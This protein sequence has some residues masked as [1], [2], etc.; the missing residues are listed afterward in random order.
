MW[1]FL[2]NNVAQRKSA[3]HEEKDATRMGSATGNGVGYR[4]AGVDETVSCS[5]ASRSTTQPFL[6]QFFE[7]G[8]TFAVVPVKSFRV[9]FPPPTVATEDE[10]A[11]R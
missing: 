3:N 8:L 9:E 10:H 5:G 11:R 2:V 4:Y 7:L 1:P 6:D